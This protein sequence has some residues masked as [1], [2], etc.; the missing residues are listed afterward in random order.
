MAFRAPQRALALQ[1]KWGMGCNVERAREILAVEGE[2]SAR[3]S[4]TYHAGVAMATHPVNA[5]Q[6]GKKGRGGK[7]EK[8]GTCAQAQQDEEIKIISAPCPH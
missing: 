6:E 8:A 7:A 4:P 2:I 5:S 1:G 3:S